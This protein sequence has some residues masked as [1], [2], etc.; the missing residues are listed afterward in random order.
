MGTYF[1]SKTAC[2]TNVALCFSFLADHAYDHDITIR[3]V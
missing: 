3:P 2:V 1:Y